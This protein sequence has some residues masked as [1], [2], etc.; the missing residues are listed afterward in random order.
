MYTH[1]YLA[2][3]CENSVPAKTG[4]FRFL[5]CDLSQWLCETFFAL[6]ILCHS[7]PLFR[8]LRLSTSSFLLFILF[9]RFA[10]ES[11]QIHIE[12]TKANDEWIGETSENANA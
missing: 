4:N 12:K 5:N 9:L 8:Y 10:A 1:T 2:E 7:F 6:Y 11:K 3:K